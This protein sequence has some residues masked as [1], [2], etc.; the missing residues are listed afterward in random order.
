M[1]AP[2]QWT[3]HDGWVPP[4]LVKEEEEGDEEE[5]EEAAMEDERT[6]SEVKTLLTGGNVSSITNMQGMDAVPG[7]ALPSTGG[8]G[9][10]CHGSTAATRLPAYCDHCVFTSENLTTGICLFNIELD[11]LEVSHHHCFA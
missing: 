8:H 5:C 10:S 1:G 3:G 4:P 6:D 9:P 7:W 2:G 11:P